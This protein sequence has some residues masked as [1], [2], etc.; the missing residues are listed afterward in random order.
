MVMFRETPWT[1]HVSKELFDAVQVQLE[2][3]KSDRRR[4]KG[5][6]TDFMIFAGRLYCSC[7]YKLQIA[8]ADNRGG[9]SYR[10][11]YVCSKPKHAGACRTRMLD[12]AA[13][14]QTAI[15]ALKAIVAPEGDLN[16]LFLHAVQSESQARAASRAQKRKSLDSEIAAAQ[17]KIDEKLEAVIPDDPVVKQSWDKMMVKLA[18]Q[19]RTKTLARQSLEAPLPVHTLAGS[20]IATLPELLDQM[21]A[22]VPIVEMDEISVRFRSLLRTLITD[23]QLDFSREDMDE[24]GIRLVFDFRG[25]FGEDDERAVF[26]CERTIDIS[27]YKAQKKKAFDALFASGVARLNEVEFEKVDG[28][29]LCRRE[30][31]KMPRE[32]RE[33]IYEGLILAFATKVP[34]SLIAD[35]IGYKAHRIKYALQWLHK[36]N[37]QQ[38]MVD[39]LQAVR[40]GLKLEARPKPFSGRQGGPKGS[41]S[42]QLMHARMAFV[43]HPL[44]AHPLC[45]RGG[46]PALRLGDGQMTAIAAALPP[47]GYWIS[48]LGKL[49]RIL[50]AFMYLVRT[51]TF[52]QDLPVE[53]SGCYFSRSPQYSLWTEDTLPRATRALLAHDGLLP[54]DGKLVFRTI[55]T[56]VPNLDT[57]PRN[58]RRQEA[59]AARRALAKKL[60]E[61]NGENE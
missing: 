21:V 7:G 15:E 46:D 61:E 12:A 27:Y 45:H 37:C 40:P 5:G 18:T 34:M 6:R 39:I 50:D 41:N 44:L 51:D 24:V 33:K 3:N 9:S 8:A 56:G 43:D 16:T 38:M 11:A 60:R 17:A 30:Y 36:T 32:L 20:R 13:V 2:R 23:A 58:V 53:F 19:V 55:P 49:R 57:R 52:F 42:I 28:A 22:K 54:P 10:R 31:G 26:V 35:R 25:V 4:K 14:E 48:R 59:R 1:A 29:P 47:E